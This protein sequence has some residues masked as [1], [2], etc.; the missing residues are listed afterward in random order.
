[1]TADEALA[2]LQS[3]LDNAT[4]PVLT[5]D[6]MGALLAKCK[7]V[8][9]S[10]LAPSDTEWD[11]TWDLNRGAAAGWRLKAGKVA[12]LHDY[13]TVGLKLSRDQ[14]RQGCLEMAREYARKIAASTPLVGPLKQRDWTY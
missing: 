14:M 3:M 6:E 12:A 2:E 10:G 7:L 13:E 4:A 9:S 1:M 8:D 5:D 11:P